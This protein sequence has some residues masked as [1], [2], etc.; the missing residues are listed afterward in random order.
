MLC[1]EQCQSQR[2][3]L[4][5]GPKRKFW[6]GELRASNALILLGRWPLPTGTVGFVLKGKAV[7][8]MSQGGVLL[9]LQAALRQEKSSVGPQSCTHHRHTIHTGTHM[10]AHTRISHTYRH[11][12]TQAHTQMHTHVYHACVRTHSRHTHAHTHA[13]SQ[14][15]LLCIS[16]WPGSSPRLFPTQSQINSSLLGI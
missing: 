15:F 2:G 10:H 4:K 7:S 9:A 11:M 6:K 8:Y 12:H 5:V 14:I 3:D 16:S 13:G 1:Q